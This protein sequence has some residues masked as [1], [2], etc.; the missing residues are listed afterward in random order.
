MR[1]KAARPWASGGPFVVEIDAAGAL[2]GPIYS[3]DQVFAD[4]QVQRLGMGRMTRIGISSLSASHS[5][6]PSKMAAR[7][8]EFGEQTGKVQAEFG[9]GK[10]EIAELRQRKVV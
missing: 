9:F 1:P 2:C 5:R 6:T 10:D 4:T 3:I 7:P 8:P